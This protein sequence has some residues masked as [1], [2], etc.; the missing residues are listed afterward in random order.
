MKKYEYIPFMAGLLMRIT[1]LCCL[2]KCIFLAEV[3]IYQENLSKSPC[4]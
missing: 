2:S 1:P 3:K 4:S